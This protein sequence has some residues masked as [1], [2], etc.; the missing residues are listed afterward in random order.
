MSSTGR[1]DIPEGIEWR[2]YFNNPLRTPAE[3]GKFFDSERITG[4]VTDGT[5]LLNRSPE[6]SWRYCDIDGLRERCGM[7]THDYGFFQW[8]SRKSPCLVRFGQVFIPGLFHECATGWQHKPVIA[9]LW[10]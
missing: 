7:G 6:L 4:I 3:E 10:E 2:F 9:A 1:R 5:A 8:R